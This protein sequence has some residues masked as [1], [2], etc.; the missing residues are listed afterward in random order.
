MSPIPRAPN[1]DTADPVA[2]MFLGRHAG[3]GGPFALLGLTHQQRDTPDIRAAAS[4]RLSQVD[5]HPLRMTPEADE[6][7]LAIHSAAAQLADP[8]LHAE[9][10]RHWPPGEPDQIPAA[11][12]SR[13]DAV[14]EQL[15]RRA[16]QIVGASGGWNPRARRRLAHIARLH[17][18]SAT[19]LLR[20][21][22]PKSRDQSRTGGRG[23]STWIM[24]RIADP[25]STGR[26][27][28]MTHAS[29]A[30][31]LVFM[32]T[33]TAIEIFSPP[34]D[35]P[36]PV[37]A[38]HSAD[39]SPGVAD[40]PLVPGPRVRIEHHAALE[41]EL[42]NILL[43]A[44]DRPD[45][46]G[47]RDARA[48]ET[49]LNRWTEATPQARDRISALIVELTTRIA[50]SPI[51]VSECL[52]PIRS[53]I[54]ASG[55][56]ETAGAQALGAVL[57]DAPDL[58]RSVRDRAAEL[59]PADT[60]PLSR[61][62]DQAVVDA[63]RSQIDQLGPEDRDAWAGWVRALGAATGASD[64]VRVQTCLLAL[65]TNLRR[66][67]PPAASWRP[68]ASA[69]ASG[70]PWRPGDPSRAWLL[71]Q[72][73][74]PAVRT[75]RLGVL[76][77]VLATDV[78]V[79]GIDPTMV[80]AA[81]ADD[82][83]R[84]VLAAIYHTRW[85]TVSASN[86]TTKNA[87][88]KELSAALAGRA[89]TNADRLSGL[90]S[91]ARANAA[92]A[93]LFAGNDVLSAELLNE[94]PPAIAPAPTPVIGGAA[95]TLDD[96][97]GTEVLGAE[98]PEHIL[99][100]LARARGVRGGLTDLAAEA[101]ATQALQGPSREVRDA[102]RSAAVSLGDDVQMLLAIERAAMRRPTAAVGDLV[103]A[104]TG[105]E[106]PD[107][108]DAS[109]TDRVR[110]ALLP[111]IADRMPGAQQGE[112]VLVEL[113]L[114]EL[115]AR[116]AGAS[117]S[118][119]YLRSL[120]SETAGWMLRNELQANDTLSAGAIDA[121]RTAFAANSR[122]MAQ[123]AAVQHRALVESIAAVAV[124]NAARPRTSVERLL[125]RMG[126][127]WAAASSVIDQLI[128]THAAEAELWRSM[129]ETSP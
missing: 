42:R 62:F 22:R 89:S 19:D 35:Q 8:A 96:A 4:R 54:G 127:E 90:V 12:R 25:D 31:M 5:R 1:P 106:L 124:S 79:P 29:L 41:Q 27:W 14:P 23:R 78:S 81:G 24:P 9:L 112:L 3:I 40:G 122:A 17:R 104:I 10:V 75:D 43:M 16:R 68:I 107:R 97:W 49:F 72:I 28:L 125:A 77:D 26:F 129:L 76:T 74:D 32:L 105:I 85:L 114:A 38:V 98:T 119:P 118:T 47:V 2:A 109:W 116:R 45:E 123:A 120:L 82:A 111:R 92:A 66:P 70:V 57:R 13:L 56:A 80:L 126:S 95:T 51:A 50:G 102:A 115:S 37:T 108:R 94:Q 100:L 11:W 91:L 93:T 58:P 113:T 33:L 7:R 88:I 65:E 86:S 48:V 44:S 117:T 87:V 71:E 30:L 84:R 67:R 46:A 59:V 73:D 99:R 6:I 34:R 110:S 121:R 64:S 36:L 18:V 61:G 53:V 103:T 39:P 128:I 60:L 83:A 20:A 52:R 69:L 15:A 101:I 55:P 21:V 63:L